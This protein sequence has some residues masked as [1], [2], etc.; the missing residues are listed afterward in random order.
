MCFA[1]PAGI[2]P[3]TGVFAK[4]MNELANESHSFYL[5][6][7]EYN[8]IYEERHCRDSCTSTIS[9]LLCNLLLKYPAVPHF[10]FTPRTVYKPQC[11]QMSFKWQCPVSS[12]NII[13][14][15]SLLKLSNSPALLSDGLL[16]KPLAC[17]CPQ[18]DCQYASCFLL[19]QPASQ[20]TSF[21]Y[22]NPVCSKRFQACCSYETL[23]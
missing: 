6:Q 16:R 10:Q 11:K 4:T 3:G 17:L 13:L 20:P 14:S 22:K 9:H 7:T 19:V 8:R 2:I 18:M 5:S 15:W 12:P 1:L 23:S 21:I